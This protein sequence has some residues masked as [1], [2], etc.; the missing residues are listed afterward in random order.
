MEWT[1]DLFSVFHNYINIS[2]LSTAYRLGF[3]LSEARV[4]GVDLARE[5]PAF[6]RLNIEDI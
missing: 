6:P 2:N 3:S 1:F 5:L 4:S